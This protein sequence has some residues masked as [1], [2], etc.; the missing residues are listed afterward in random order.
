MAAHIS[1]PST[2]TREQGIEDTL[3]NNMLTTTADIKTKTNSTKRAQ[4]GLSSR[5]SAKRLAKN[6]KEDWR[7]R[8]RNTRSG[9]T[10]TRADNCKENG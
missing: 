10:S 8:E 3:A 2:R 9:G 7:M 6:T 4:N 5:A 1:D